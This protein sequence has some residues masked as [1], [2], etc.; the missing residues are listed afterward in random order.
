MFSVKC[1]GLK[2]INIRPTG[3]PLNK[4][5][6]YYYI[7]YMLKKERQEKKKRNFN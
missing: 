6:P 3:C 4:T 1:S 2:S 7:Y 5:K